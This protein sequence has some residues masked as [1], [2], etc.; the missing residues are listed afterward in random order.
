MSQEIVVLMGEP[1]SESSHWLVAMLQVHGHKVRTSMG[2]KPALTQIHSDLPALVLLPVQMA[3]FSGFELCR[4]LRRHERTKN[5]P[6]LL[7]ASEVSEVVEAFRA[8]ATDVIRMPLQRAEVL[9]RVESHLELAKL[10]ATHRRAPQNSLATAD[11]GLRAK[12]AGLRKNG[13]G[14]LDASRGTQRFGVTADL[15]EQPANENQPEPKRTD[16]LPLI[17]KLP[18]AV[19]LTDHCGRVEYINPQF[20]K[21]FGYELD[22]LTGPRESWQSDCPNEDHRKSLIDALANSAGQASRQGNGNPPGDYLISGKDGTQH[23]VEIYGSL[24]GNRKLLL[25]LDIT[26]PK[27]AGAPLSETAEPFPVMAGDPGK[28]RTFLSRRRLAFT[29][30]TPQQEVS[31]GWTDALHLDDF[32]HRLA[33][34][35][36]SFDN[37][38]RSR[39]DNRLEP[40]GDRWVIPTAT[41]QSATDRT[42][43]GHIG[44]RTSLGKSKRRLQQMLVAQKL[45]SLG[46]V[47]RLV[48]HDFNNL[49]GCILANADLTLSELDNESPARESLDRIETVVIGASQVVRQIMTY[50]GEEQEN[51]EAVN[52]SQLIQQMSQLLRLCIPKRAALNIAIPSSLVVPK[53]NAA[54][55]RQVVMNLILNAGEAIGDQGGAISITGK[56]GCSY[57]RGSRREAPNSDGGYIC[58]EISDTGTGMTQEILE[59]IFDPFFSTKVAGRGFGLAAVQTIVRS[60]GG[61]IQVA[62]TPGQGTTFQVLLPSETRLPA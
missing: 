20:T 13:S 50:I 29:S 16:L 44:S 33:I 12:A 60:H 47:A 43:T 18:L 19:A 30:R 26:K 40:N 5:I 14:S 36:A 3:D 58:L 48:A 53:A 32:D 46:V 21:T 6:L 31:N 61:T 11:C 55:L 41:P 24:A 1:E 8:G 42:L 23:S 7:V 2:G 27:R 35:I 39:L 17:E 37:P 56:C 34:Y 22:D 38:N 4:R 15:A 49:F 10:R 57:A 51:P 25:F 28:L 59:R 9:A 54:Q 45:E 62:S 52:L